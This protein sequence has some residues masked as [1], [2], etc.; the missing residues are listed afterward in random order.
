MSNLKCF[1]LASDAH[2]GGSY[3]GS[4][5]NMKSLCWNKF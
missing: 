5:G 3:G 4:L 2:A 1:A